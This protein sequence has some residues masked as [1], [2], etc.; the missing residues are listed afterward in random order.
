MVD[1]AQNCAVL[2]ISMV[3]LK[4][5]SNQGVL[6]LVVARGGSKGVPRKNLRMVAGKPLVAWPVTA[7]RDSK[8]LTRLVISTDDNDIAK[9]AEQFGCEVPFMRPAELAQDHTIVIDVIRHA[10]LTL[11]P[12]RD[13]PEYVV[14][15]QP[16]SPQ[17]TSLDIDQAVSLAR[18]H[19]AD[20]VVTVYQHPSIHPN[21]MYKKDPSG[22]L[23]P[24][25]GKAI[26]TRRQDQEP[27]FFRTGIV[28]VAKSSLILER[29]TIYG[30]TIVPYEVDASRSLCID[31]PE[32]LEEADR[33]LSRLS[34]SLVK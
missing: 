20:T 32:E 6:G 33:Y 1:F 18:T 30:D 12:N 29:N 25:T 4:A 16:T 31:T 22:H 5:V 21:L 17:V 11:Y 24:Y 19:R 9:T 8:S 7:G 15:L 14:L 26:M 28:Y 27:V 23:V 2:S 13:Y 10:L 3:N 34:G